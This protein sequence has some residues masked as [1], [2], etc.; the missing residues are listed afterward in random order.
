MVGLALANAAAQL[1]FRVALIEQH[2][3]YEATTR[4]SNRVS[5]INPASERLLT[6][7]GTWSLIPDH[8][9]TA[10][11]TMHVWD[12]LGTGSLD[13]T[14]DSLPA[15]HLGHIIE[16][17]H[18]IAA[19]MNQAQLND[20]IEVFQP[21]QISQFHSTPDAVIVTLNSGL[22]L[23][24]KILVGAEGK[25]SQVR[26]ALG[27]PM[28]RWEYGHTAIVATVQHQLAHR[29][30]ARQVFLASGPLAFLPMS[31]SDAPEQIS[32]IV[33]SA[34]TTEAQRLLSLSDKTFNRE[35]VQAF[36]HQLG[37]TR[38][39][40]QRQSFPLSAQHSSAYFQGRVVIL[41]D[42]AHSI[43]PLAGLGVN[44]GF[45]DAGTLIDEW[46]RANH[47]KLD[48]ADHRV[49]RRFQRQRRLHNWSVIG[50]MEGLKRGFDQTNPTLV[51]ARNWG[52]SL[53]NAH[54]TLKRPLTLSAMGDF[55]TPLP[56]LC[57]PIGK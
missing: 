11:R 18:I 51:I 3:V 23:Q 14:A 45:L 34:Q 47:L 57:Q 30:C 46:R 4:F 28:H 9:K 56:T 27:L 21:D 48:I 15:S 20:H 52:L 24:G 42:A 5:A 25:H 7:L 35:L 13:F 37:E 55:A 36:E 17:Q 19:L 31:D 44:L 40:T 6:R 10:Y 32:S 2:P 54:T 38:L 50:L 22:T 53:L 8:Q 29:H 12:G 33:W 39:I 43:H 41:G 1:N 49:L 16:N 26:Q